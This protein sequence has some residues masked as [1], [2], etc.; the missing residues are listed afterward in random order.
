MRLIKSRRVRWWE[1]TTFI[2]EMRNR[3]NILGQKDSKEE[4]I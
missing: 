3:Y 1:H 2:G 4:S